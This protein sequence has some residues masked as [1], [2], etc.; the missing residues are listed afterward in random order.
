MGYHTGSIGWFK[1]TLDMARLNGVEHAF[2]ESYLDSIEK[3]CEVPFKLGLPDGTSTQFGDSWKGEP[4][5]LWSSLKEWGEVF[6]RDDF[7][8]VASEGKEG[9]APDSTAFALKSSGFYSMRSSWNKDAVCLVLKCG[10]NGG[11]HCQ[12]DNGTFELYAGGRTLMPDAGSYIYSGDPEGR[13]WFR[14]TKVHQTLT[15]NGENSAYAPS[16]RLWKPG[17]DMDVLVVENAS[18]PEL[19]H[20]RAVFFVDKKYFLI[21]DDAIGNATGDID[22]HFQFAPGDAVYDSA[23]YSV[24]TSF[25]DGW[26]L[27]VRANSQEAM[28]LDEE[29]GWV[30]FVYTKKEKRPAF[31]YRIN[32]STPD[33]VRFVTLVIPYGG[34]QSPSIEAQVSSDSRPG[35]KTLDLTVVADGVAK[36]IRCV[37]PEAP[38]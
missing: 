34:K 9:K 5:R 11:G 30:S 16:L 22:V 23:N 13:A 1:R 26:N 28:Q 7:L 35:G 37:I 2:P 14:Q 20:R 10:P 25:N 27:M 32:K 12:P 31:R 3:M 24:Q 18:Y 33:A 38:H 15:L 29:E 21:V 8:Y 17:N 6:K 4:G 36:E 19:T